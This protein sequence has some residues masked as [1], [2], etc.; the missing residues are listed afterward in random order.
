MKHFLLILMLLLLAAPAQAAG[1][2]TLFDGY[3]LDMP[4]EKV[5][6][7]SGAEPCRVPG[8][9][10]HLCLPATTTYAGQQWRQS[11]LLSEGKLKMVLLQRPFAPGAFRESVRAILD[12]GF[13]LAEMTA[14]GNVFDAIAAL[15]GGRKNFERLQEEFA[16]RSAGA[17]QLAYSF[18]DKRSMRNARSS[19]GLRD[20][21]RQAP[22][23]TRG[24][25]LSHN[26]RVMTLTF[27]A[28]GAQAR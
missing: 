19:T 11:F 7:R 5:Q 13:V 10:Q 3:F 24:V 27:L 21:L 16:R 9:E 25:T 15:R 23:S 4:R 18:L 17:R 20:F 28:P 2:V 12:D 26:G 14:D 8:L 22:A 6:R 1:R